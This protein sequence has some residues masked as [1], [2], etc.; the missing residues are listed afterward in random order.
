MTPLGTDARLHLAASVADK[1]PVKLPQVSRIELLASV[2]FSVNLNLVSVQGNAEPGKF[3][4]SSF[5]ILLK[6]SKL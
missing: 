5:L 3:V 4:I 1:L 6:T 2:E